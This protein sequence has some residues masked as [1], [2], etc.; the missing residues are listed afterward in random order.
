[1]NHEGT[2]SEKRNFESMTEEQ[3]PRTFSSGVENGDKPSK[4]KSRLKSFLWNFFFYVVIIG[5]IVFG[6]PRFLVWKLKTNYPMAAITSGSMWPVL[7]Q[8]DLVFIKGIQNNDQIQVGDIVVFRNRANGTLTIHRV[9][10][11][12]DK[13]TTKGDANFSED[14]PVEYKDVIGETLNWND[15]KPVRI[16]KLGLITIFTNSLREPTNNVSGE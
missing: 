6:L 1:M 11:L 10:K 3:N 15:N 5:G 13:I 9:I 2:E 4:K 14:A 16:P 7:K 8:S 12:G